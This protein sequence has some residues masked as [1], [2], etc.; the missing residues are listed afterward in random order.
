MTLACVV[1]LA[2][3]CASAPFEPDSPDASEDVL[4]PFLKG[5]SP[6]NFVAMQRGVDMARLVDSL[7]DWDAIRLGALGPMDAKASEVLGR[8]RAAFLI[9]ATEQYGVARAE[10]FAL[11]VLHSTCDDEM[12]AV[13]NLLAQDKHLGQTLGAMATVREQLHERGLMIEAHAE[14]PERGGDVLRGLGRAGRDALSSSEVSAG[15]RYLDL[16]FKREQLPQPYRQALD[17]V[18]QALVKQHFSADNVAL[19][20]FDHLT[21]GVPLGFFHL[22]AG[23]AQGASSLAAGRYEQATR[24]LAPAAL[25][26]AMYAGGKGARALRESP[27]PVL[28]MER[29]KVVVARLEE[30]LGINAARD[31][32]RYLQARRENAYLAAEWGEAGVLAL[33]ET[34]G[35]A[36]KA[37][38][39]LAQAEHERPRTPSTRTDSSGS[40][41]GFF[42]DAPIRNAHLAGQRHPVTGVPFDAEGYPDFKAAGVVQ[43]EVRI[44]YSGSRAGDFAAANKAAGLKQTPKGMTWHHHQDRATLQLVPTDIHARTGHTGGFSRGP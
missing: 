30:Q 35:N 38:A 1:L 24:E 20:S 42:T 34:R 25:M 43:A 19:G 32:L 15:A 23:T 41:G 9:R 26:V 33:H 37:Q 5:A 17:E 4:A 29:L 39:M 44:P 6:A 31:V 28:S 27:N 22:M 7:S 8:K 21:F 2:T 12:R 13:L 40:A 14:R 11:F 18:E 10:V 36:A 3:G 16:S